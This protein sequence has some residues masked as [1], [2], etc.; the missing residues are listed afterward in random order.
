MSVSSPVGVESYA[1]GNIVF[2]ATHLIYFAIYGALT[3]QT[4]CADLHIGLLSEPCSHQVRRFAHA[5]LLRSI[6]MT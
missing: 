4:W 5:S 6:D 3:F 2:L 1:R